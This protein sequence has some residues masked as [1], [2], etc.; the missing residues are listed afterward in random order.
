M[1]LQVR[2][3]IAVLMRTFLATVAAIILATLVGTVL[4]PATGQDFVDTVV[5]VVVLAFV[6]RLMW[7]CLKWWMDRIVVTDHRI[8]EV[9]GVMSRSVA[10]LPLW[11]MTDL[12]YRRTVP[13]RLLGYGALVLET[14][15]QQQAL[16]TIDYLP[17]PDYFYRT[18][19]SLVTAR[20]PEL[21]PHR[22]GS[23]QPPEWPPPDEP[24]WT[25]PDEGDTGPLP[26]VIV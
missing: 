20:G 3:H 6:V 10:S 22:P 2:R 23:P 14:A 18:I 11:K 26:R 16:G 15:G 9:S 8:F 12:T 5:G 13:G 21:Q 17:R 19:T 25:P 1:V 7:M 24:Q 4:S